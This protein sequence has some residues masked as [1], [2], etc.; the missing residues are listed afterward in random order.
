MAKAHSNISQ[1]ILHINILF[2]F[3]K[4]TVL[5]IQMLAVKKIF[6]T[7]FIYPYWFARIELLMHVNIFLFQDV[8]T[9]PF[10]TFNIFFPLTVIMLLLNCF[11]DA[12]P[13]YLDYPRG[14][15]GSTSIY[16]ECLIAEYL[17]SIDLI[18]IIIF[19]AFCI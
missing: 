10:V 13:S 17:H 6:V 15:V 1:L 18:K 4:Y 9:W 5:R 8:D 7:N 2:V 12:R 3:Y 11:A 14:E 19:L 16:K